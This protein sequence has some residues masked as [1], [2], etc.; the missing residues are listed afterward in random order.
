MEDDKFT[1]RIGPKFMEGCGDYNVIGALAKKYGG[2]AVARMKEV[3]L[4]FV[5]RPRHLVMQR[6]PD[7]WIMPEYA[8]PCFAKDLLYLQKEGVTIKFEEVE[9]DSP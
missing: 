1:L 4:E 9:A 6:G 3:T 8:V 5:T 7:H 2:T